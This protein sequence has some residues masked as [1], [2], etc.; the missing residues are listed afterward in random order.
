MALFTLSSCGLINEDELDCTPY[1]KIRFRFDMNMLYAD[2]FSTQVGEID[3]Y[4]LDTDGKVVWH[5]HEEGE[6]LKQEGYLMDLPI[7]PGKYD[8]IAWARKRHDNASDFLLQGGQAPAAASDLRMSLTRGH[9]GDTAHSSTDIH[10][11][12]HGIVKGIELPD[13]WG[14]H[15]VTLPLTKDTNSIR[16]QL[17]HL[18]GKDIKADDFDFKI[19]DMS[20]DIDYD[21]SLLE[22]EPIE[23]RAWSKREG[24]AQT[25]LPVN[26]KAVTPQAVHS[27]VAEMTTSRLQTC[28]RPVL[29]VTRASDGAKVVEIPV[30]DYFLM[31]K[32]EYNRK[33]EDDEYLDRQDDYSMTL[34]MHDDGTWYRNVIEILSWRVVYQSP[35]L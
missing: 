10:A 7:E 21:N 30:I 34:F 2:A 11:L 5:G 28:R 8:L 27:L 20:G 4:V 33:M 16:I 15:M 6:V 26:D 3:L 13:E 22:T 29:T 31:V 19:T 18:S 23:Y 14:T 32:G 9:E 35:D 17:V 12:F 1:Y 24:L 25:V